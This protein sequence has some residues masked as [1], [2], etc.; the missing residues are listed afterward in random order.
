MVR[1]QLMTIFEQIAINCEVGVWDSFNEVTHTCNLA[2]FKATMSKSKSS[3]MYLQIPL[4]LIHD[5]VQ[6]GF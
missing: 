5:Y 4:M 1:F 2:I 6:A 3:I